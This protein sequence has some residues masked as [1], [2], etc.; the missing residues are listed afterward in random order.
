MYL[1]RDQNLALTG[2]FGI[3]SS[4]G[5]ISNFG[6]NTSNTQLEMQ[7]LNYNNWID[8]KTS[9]IFLEF[10]IYTPQNHYFSYGI[11]IFEF[12][13]GGNIFL[14]EAIS[15]VKLDIYSG[16]STVVIIIFQI[17]SLFSIFAITGFVLYSILHNKKFYK[18]SCL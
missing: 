15:T 7:T 5:F 3:Y 4:N 16:D 18:V 14:N 10:I 17:L 9:S 8:F 12:F 6:N 2:D 1:F 11:Y 13:I